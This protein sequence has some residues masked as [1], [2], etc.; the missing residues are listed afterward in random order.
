MN[1]E[2]LTLT[3]WGEKH[4]KTREAARYLLSSGQLPAAMWAGSCWIIPADTLPPLGAA[5]KDAAPPAKA[6]S[7]F[8]TVSAWGKKHG[9]TR[10]SI[11]K[12]INA[13]LLP[14][15]IWAGTCWII[16]ADTPYPADRREK[17]GEYKNWRK[18]N[19]GVDK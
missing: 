17:T 8:L 10:H 13:G 15:A 14:E 12:A 11:H 19:I 1:T 5:E 4:G 6:A 9:K 3:A 18:K 7:P 16:P 2:Y